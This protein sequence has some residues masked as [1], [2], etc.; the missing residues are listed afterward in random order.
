MKLVVD[1]LKQIGDNAH[2]FDD[3]V[4]HEVVPKVVH[5]Q[6]HDHAIQTKNE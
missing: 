5:E 2:G 4:D 3:A 1:A 6:D